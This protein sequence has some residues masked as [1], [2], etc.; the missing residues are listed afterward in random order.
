MGAKAMLDD[1]L[2]TR[3]PKPD[4]VLAFH[5]AAALPAGV[6][7]D[8]AGLCARQRRQ[9]R[10]HR[11]AA[12]AGTAPSRRRPRIRSSSPS[13]IVMTLQTLV[14]REN[15][16]ARARGRHRRQLPCRHQEQ[17]H[18]RRSQAAADGAQLHA[19]SA[20]AAARR[21]RAASRAAR[22]SR[23]GMPDDQMP[24]ST[25]ARASRRR[26]T[27]NTRRCSDTAAELVRARTS[28]PTA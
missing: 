16:P 18:F 8:H 21:H 3:F 7:G 14:S 28:A 5:D 12:S 6:I 17:H 13:R 26:A 20:Q 25:V 15:D 27:F 22:R 24:M 4:Y 2:F 9:R 19:G 11:A 23:P 1:G 10:H